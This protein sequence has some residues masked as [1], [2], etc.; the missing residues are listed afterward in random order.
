M[1]FV[2]DGESSKLTSNLFQRYSERIARSG[3]RLIPHTN[4]EMTAGAQASSFIYIQP[5]TV[6]GNENQSLY[7]RAAVT[8]ATTS[9][10]KLMAGGRRA[11]CRHSVPIC[12]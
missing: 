2:G 11:H 3:F 5:I 9:G 7:A 10:V 1:S 8:N 4:T 12:N 6:W